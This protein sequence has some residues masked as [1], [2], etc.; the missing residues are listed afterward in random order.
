MESPDLDRRSFSFVIRSSEELRSGDVV[1]V[2][3][4]KE[5]SNGDR[6]VL[7]VPEKAILEEAS[8]FPSA[9]KKT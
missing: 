2:R 1:I 6:V 4:V 5:D 7:A 8:K 9:P 3:E